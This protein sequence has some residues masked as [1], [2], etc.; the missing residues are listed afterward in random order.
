MTELLDPV[1]REASLCPSTLAGL[2]S[3]A[4]S[5]RQQNKFEKLKCGKKIPKQS[6]RLRGDRLTFEGMVHCP[7]V[8][9]GEAG[10]QLQFSNLLATVH[11]KSAKVLDLLSES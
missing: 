6:R 10:A 2:K 8:G 11:H 1:C 4:I 3:S 9:V 5:D 7:G